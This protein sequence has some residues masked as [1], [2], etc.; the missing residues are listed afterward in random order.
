MKCPVC[1]MD[2]VQSAKEILTTLPGIFLP[3]PNCSIR[4]L[5]KRA[6]SPSLEYGLPCSCGKRFIDEVFTHMYV[7]MVEEGDLTTT[8][9]LIAVGSPL[10]HPGFAMDRP[11]FLPQK[12]LT[13]LTSAATR[14]TAERLMNEVPELRGVIKKENFIPGI[15]NP[16]F[17]SVP[18]VYELLAGCDVRADIFPLRTGPLVMYK[19]QSRIHIEFP[20]GGYPKIQ[21]VV[22]HVGNPPAK[23]F[24]DACSGVGT[25]GLAAA[26]LGVPRVVLND[27]WYASA[28]WSA[29]N[30][31]VNR[32]YLQIDRV[33]I[34]EQEED[35]EKHP[36]M[37]EPVKI[38]E[39]EGKQKIEVFQG[40]FR[41]LYTVLSMDP[42][43][44]TVFDM[45]DKSDTPALHQILDEWKKNVGGEVFIP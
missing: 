15:T 10:V 6:P 20:R 41:R 31:E 11:P 30:L 24:V 8:D 2:C 29:F 44:I 9:P 14:K 40:D 5:D 42:S 25:L 21:A 43:P 45:F 7:I 33:R 22:Q 23:F 37:K 26:C 3:C 36:V 13:L 19:Q 27:A 34:Y 35:M 28:F 17:D 1:G 4:V 32:E 12:S 39:T 18:R 16:N 38:A